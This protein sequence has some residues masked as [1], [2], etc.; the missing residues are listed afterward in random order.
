M[1]SCTMDGAEGEGNDDDAPT[2]TS[3]TLARPIHQVS[4]VVWFGSRG[5]EA[6]TPPKK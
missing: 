2:D 3:K 5:A 6:W 1:L 4:L